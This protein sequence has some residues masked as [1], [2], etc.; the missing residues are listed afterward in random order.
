MSYEPENPTSDIGDDAQRW[1]F[2]EFTRISGTFAALEPGRT[3]LELT[4]PTANTSTLTQTPLKIEA[5]DAQIL[6][7]V[8][9]ESSLAN[10]TIIIA[11]SGLWLVVFSVVADIVQHTANY[12]RGAVAQLRNETDDISYKILDITTVA[13]YQ[14]FMKFSISLPVYI[15]GD[16]IGKEL[17]MYTYATTANSIVFTDIQLLEFEMVLLAEY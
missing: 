7:E 9:G 14:D 5:Y 13:R 16:V 1:L 12:T 10:S 6:P 15:S 4:V 8:K 17:A 2:D 11:Q 3:G